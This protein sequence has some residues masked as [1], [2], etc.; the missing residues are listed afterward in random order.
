MRLSIAESNKIAEIYTNKVLVEDMTDGG[1]LGGGGGD[2]NDLEND[3]DYA[4]GDNRIPYVMG[5]QSRKGPV[6]K[7][8]KKKKLPFLAD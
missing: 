8:K 3:D 2:I 7:G 5:I 1:V 6:K 4:P